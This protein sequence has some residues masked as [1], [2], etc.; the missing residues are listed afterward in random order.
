MDK[1][2][3]EYLKAGQTTISNLILRNYPSLGL[4]EAELVLLMELMSEQQAG[5]LFPSIEKTAQRMGKE[6]KEV[7]QMLHGL[8]E[9]KVMQIVSVP[10]EDGKSQDVYRFDLL[11]E[12]L[13]ILGKRKQQSEGQNNR[14]AAQDKVYSSIEVEFGRPLSPIEIETIDS[15]LHQDNYAPD[16]IIL[17]LREAVLNQAY[18]LKYID[19][20]LLSW[21]RQNIK[22]AQDVERAKQKVRFKS[23]KGL[24]E[25]KDNSQSDKPA[26]PLYRWSDNSGQGGNE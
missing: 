4:D 15:W 24:F 25:T 19:K 23:K 13:E 12:K 7:Y 9:K 3:E 14:K 1:T 2:F 6:I 10:D 18:S 8:I 11:Y 17:A 22:T 26:I 20:I 5:S 21:E 16:L